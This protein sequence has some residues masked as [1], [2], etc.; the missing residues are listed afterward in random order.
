VTISMIVR[1]VSILALRNSSCVWQASHMSTKSWK[2]E[3]VPAARPV[4]CHFLRRQPL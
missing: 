3:N 4:E 2:S 1:S